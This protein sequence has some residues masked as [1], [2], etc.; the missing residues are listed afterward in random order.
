MTQA[1]Q[2][3]RTLTELDHTRVSRLLGRSGAGVPASAEAIQEML[4]NS[5]VVPSPEVPHTVV[6]M[7]SRVLLDD[8]SDGTS[9]EVTLCYPQDADASAG[10]VSVLSPAGAALLGLRA[11]AVARWHGP[12]G[13]E[14]VARVASILFQPE[15]A[16][17]YLR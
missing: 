2:D 11:G 6:T 3:E 17:D 1:I 9:F 5:E 8:A 10:K 15:A 14:R 7:Y 13:D 12:G 16:G 4:D